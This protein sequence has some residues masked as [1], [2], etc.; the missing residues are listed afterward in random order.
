MLR[1]RGGWVLRRAAVVG[2]LGLAGGALAA[3]TVASPTEAVVVERGA[4]VQIAFTAATE[5]PEFSAAFENAIRLAVEQHPTIRGFPVQLNVIETTCAG[6]NAAV[7]ASIVANAQN[8]AVIGHVC[9]AGFRS[10]LPVYEGAG[11]VTLSGSAT[12]DD[13]PQLGPTV[14]NRTIVR[15]GDD[16]ERW[17]S[18]V[19]AVPSVEAWSLDYEAR[20]AMTP[21]DLAV[22]YFDAASLLLRRL[23][24][25]SD[26]VDGSLVINRAALATAVRGTT[27]FQGVT[28]R[29]TLDPATGNRVDDAAALARCGGG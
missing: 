9:S 6:D 18:D 8:A 27:K 1:A 29:I 13:V 25:S 5:F 4:P 3:S 21:P 15:D 10:A 19:L 11:V 22:F 28:C 7:A 16:L 23:Q 17:M 26:I 12:A 14:F 2:A 20:F 24:Q